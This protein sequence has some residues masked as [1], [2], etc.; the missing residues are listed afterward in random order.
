M[1]NCSLPDKR[2]N[3]GWTAGRYLNRIQS[4]SIPALPVVEEKDVPFDCG[5]MLNIVF[6]AFFTETH[7]CLYL[8]LLYQSYLLEVMVQ[9]L[10]L[11]LLCS[12]ALRERK[13]K[14]LK[15]ADLE[16]EHAKHAN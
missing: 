16:A 13:K 7:T 4:D 10:K 9:T 15:K 14:T 8:F 11:Q 6:F 3:I 2:H 5:G 1:L 12:R